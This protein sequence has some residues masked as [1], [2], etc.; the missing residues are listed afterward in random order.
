MQQIMLDEKWTFRRGMLDSVGMLEADPGKAVDLPHDGMI[1]LSVSKEA[2]ASVDSGYFPGDTCNY[3]KNIKVPVEWKEEC[4]GLKFDGAMMHASIDI[5]G[6]KV[7]EHHYGYAPFYVDIT[8]YV[9]F[10]EE[11]RITV[12]VN[13]GVQPSSR[14]YTGSGLFRGLVLCHSPR[15]HIQNDGVFVY[16]KEVTG[17]APFLPSPGC[18]DLSEQ[19]VLPLP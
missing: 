16:T 3:T 4:I 19:H 5:N 15:V 17:E 18:S 12:N 2:A 8:D 6:C 10:G 13:T 11:N 7:G 14:W 9:A 1:S